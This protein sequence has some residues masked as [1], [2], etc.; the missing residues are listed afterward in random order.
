MTLLIIVISIVGGVLV[1]VGWFLLGFRLGSS[2]WQ[3]RLLQVQM[4][5][6]RARRQLHDLTR[7][8]FVAMADHTQGHIQRSSHEEA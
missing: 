3:S 8:A 6:A 7:E 1:L 2:Q 5:S 4:E